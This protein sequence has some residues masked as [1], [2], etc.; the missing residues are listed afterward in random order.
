[1]ILAVQLCT[2]GLQQLEVLWYKKLV[3]R[4]RT[5]DWYSSFDPM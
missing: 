2:V 5:A 4:S 1:M 3:S